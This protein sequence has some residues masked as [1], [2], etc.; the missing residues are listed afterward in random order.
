MLPKIDTETDVFLKAHP[1]CDGRGVIVGILDSGVDAAAEGL[2]VDV[3][4]ISGLLIGY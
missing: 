3:E 2:K 1:D 4:T